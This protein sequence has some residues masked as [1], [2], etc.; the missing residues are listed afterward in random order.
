MTATTVGFSLP[1]EDITRLDQLADYFTQ[2]NKS[3]F[4]RLALKRMEALQRAQQLRDL[5]AYGVA[6]TAE[7]GLEDVPVEE[8][9]RRALAAHARSQ[10]E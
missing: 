7:A 6:R 10:A 3:A 9:V 2:G 5:Q 8:V 4:L 1:E